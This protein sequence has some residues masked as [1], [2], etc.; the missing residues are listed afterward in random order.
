MG[1]M[2]EIRNRE[3]AQRSRELAESDAAITFSADDAAAQLADA[4]RFSAGASSLLRADGWLP[5]AS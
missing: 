5:P 2:N 1:L 4:E 3:T